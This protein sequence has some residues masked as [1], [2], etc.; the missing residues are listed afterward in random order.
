MSLFLNWKHTIEDVK[1]LS[2]CS[3]CRNTKFEAALFHEVLHMQQE[4]T[5]EG[6]TI[7]NNVSLV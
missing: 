6:P 3:T 1:Y 7:G 2:N 4:I 5:D